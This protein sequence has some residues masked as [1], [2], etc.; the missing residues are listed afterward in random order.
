MKTTADQVI[1]SEA[2]RKTRINN[3]IPIHNIG[4]SIKIYSAIAK[5]DVDT[6]LQN[7]A[8][9]TANNVTNAVIGNPSIKN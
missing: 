1:L 2:A 8:K 9:I 4:I 5:K 3:S 6:F 7:M